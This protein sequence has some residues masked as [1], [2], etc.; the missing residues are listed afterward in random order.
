MNAAEIAKLI[1]TLEPA[2]D[3]VHQPSI[4]DL[5][6]LCRA[7]LDAQAY[8][9]LVEQVAFEMVD[10]CDDCLGPISRVEVRDWAEQLTEKK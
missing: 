6:I 3:T 10:T 8:R 7:V 5:R 2:D 9:A 4:T 1:L